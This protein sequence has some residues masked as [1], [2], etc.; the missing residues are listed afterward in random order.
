MENLLDISST[1][2]KLETPGLEILRG[3]RSQTIIQTVAFIK[4]SNCRHLN[5][6]QHQATVPCETLNSLS[7]AQIFRSCSI[8]RK[9]PEFSLCLQ[10][11]CKNKGTVTTLPCLQIISFYIPVH[12]RPVNTEVS[13]L[14]TSRQARPPNTAGTFNCINDS[15][16]SE[17]CLLV[18]CSL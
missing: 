13:Q 7:S 8:L 6:Y 11:K 10:Q 1:G 14:I 12:Q 17:T 18:C 5:T 9:M 3:I 16:F 4:R 15:C 2:L